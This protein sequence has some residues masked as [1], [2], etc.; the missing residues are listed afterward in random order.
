MN[1]IKSIVSLGL[2]FVLIF[3]GSKISAATGSDDVFAQ[4]AVSMGAAAS[5]QSKNNFGESNAALANE[6]GDVD[7]A[8]ANSKLDLEEINPS[9]SSRAVKALGDIP[10]SSAIET[11]FEQQGVAL[12][13]T[14][15]WGAEK[16]L[17]ETLTNILKRLYSDKDSLKFRFILTSDPIPYIKSTPMDLN[18]K[19][20]DRQEARWLKETRTYGNRD[21]AFPTNIV[22][23][24]LLTVPVKDGIEIELSAGLIASTKTIDELAGQLAIQLAK[25]NNRVYGLEEDLRFTGNQETVEL[26]DQL[27]KGG[28][29]EEAKKL[30]K[31]RDQIVAEF[32]AIERMAA[33]GFYPWAIYD[34][35]V[36]EY[37]WMADVFLNSR[38]HYVGRKLTS[39]ETN[40]KYNLED[41]S[42]PIRLL[43]QS[44]YMGYL[45]GID[46]GKGMNLDST[47]YSDSLKNIRL[48]MVAFTQPFYFGTAVH[49]API[50]LGAG[51]A[52]THFFFPEVA[53]W[54][55]SA[56]NMTT[57]SVSNSVSS[58]VE[59]SGWGA[60]I[61]DLATHVK[62]VGK[63]ILDNCYLGSEQL[64]KL[65][66][67]GVS[68][69]VKAATKSVSE[70][71]SNYRLGLA[72]GTAA[73][74]TAVAVKYSDAIAEILHSLARSSELAKADFAA[75]KRKAM[76]EEAQRNG[77]ATESESKESWNFDYGKLGLYGKFSNV[78][79]GASNSFRNGYRV[80]LMR[81][82]ALGENSRSAARAFA[83][84][85]RAFTAKAIK[86]SGYTV[87]AAGS[88]TLKTWETFDR[89][90]MAA[91]QA[92][93]NSA[94]WGLQLG[95]KGVKGTVKGGH[96]LIFSYAPK[97]IMDTKNGL[98][99]AFESTAE[100]LKQTKKSIQDKW[101]ARQNFI[102]ER[103]TNR[104]RMELFLSDDSLKPSE[105]LILINDISLAKSVKPQHELGR[106]WGFMNPKEI[107]K[108]DAQD[109]IFRALNRWTIQAKHLQ[110]DDRDFVDLAQLIDSKS[111]EIIDFSKLT[112][113]QIEI[114]VEFINTLKNKGGEQA[115]KLLN[116]TIKGR[117][118][119]SLFV[120]NLYSYY[121]IEQGKD[122]PKGQHIFDSVVTSRTALKKRIISQLYK[123][124]TAEIAKYLGD[125][126]TE[127][128]TVRE[129]FLA[130][131]NEMW[132]K[133]SF[134]NNPFKK[135]IDD[136]NFIHPLAAVK[137]YSQLTPVAT[138]DPS[139]SEVSLDNISGVLLEKPYQE[140]MS[141]VFE[142]WMSRATSISQLEEMVTSETKHFKVNPKIFEK[143]FHKKLASR[144]DL[145][146]SIKD[147]ETFYK[148]DYFWSTEGDDEKVSVLERP[149]KALLEAKR[150]AHAGS[151]IWN[152]DPIQS[153]RIH[154]ESV[155]KLIAINEYPQDFDA[156]VEI[157]KMLTS[158]GVSTVTDDI[159]AG[160]MAKGTSD[161]INKLEL[162]AVEEGRVFDQTLRDEFAIRQIRRT[163][164]YNNLM[165]VSH[166]VFRDR[167]QQIQELLIVVQSLMGD[168]GIRYAEFLEEVS[169]DIDSK[170]YEAEIFHKA[171]LSR[172]V[173]GASQVAEGT[174]SDSRVSMLHDILPYVKTW[175]AK[176]QYEFLLYLRGNIDATKFIKEQF[177]KFGPERVRKMF[178]GLPIEASMGFAVLYLQGT[179]LSGKKKIDEGYGKKL[180]EYF[181]TKG[182]ND[183]VKD[184]ASLMLRGLLY[185]LEY[186]KNQQFQVRVLSALVAMKP[187]ENK[188]TSNV[189]FD[190]KED[191]SVGETLK[192]ILEQFPGVGPKI[193]QFLVGTNKLPEHINKVLIHTQDNS[194][195]PSRHGMFGDIA[196]IV[197]KGDDIGISLGALLGAGSL[198][199]STLG[200]YNGKPVALQIFR[201][202]VQNNSDLQVKVL[203]GMIDYL[204][205]KGGKEWAFLR[206][207][208]DGAVNAVNREKEYT[209][210]SEKT[211]I[212]RES[213]YSNFSDDLFTVKV[214][215]QFP[216]NKRLLVSD[217]AKGISFKD[218]KFPEEDKQAVGI[219][220]LQMEANILYGKSSGI[221]TYDTDRHAGNYL[222]DINKVD[223][224]KHYNIAP[225]DFGQLTTIT[226]KQRDRVE[227]LFSYSVV[228]GQFG[229]N[230]WIV[231]AIA[232][233]LGLEG[234]NLQILKK[235]I[236]DF[237]PLKISADK[238]SSSDNI[239]EGGDAGKRV[240]EY[241]SL[242]AAIN[243]TFRDHDAGAVRADVDLT[244]LDPDLR[245]GKLDF[246]YTDFV[247]GIIQL[248]QYEDVIDVPSHIMTPS[249]I[250]S[251]RV[252]DKVAVHLEKMELSRMQKAGIFIKDAKRWVEAKLEQKEFTPLHY[253]L[254]RAELDKFSLMGNKKQN[255]PSSEVVG[256]HQSHQA[257]ANRCLQF[258]R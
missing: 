133:K 124:N 114:G 69:S 5:E 121:Q 253:R 45:Q 39:A 171:K 12:G 61:S 83:K 189:A 93:W 115:R 135:L 107:N 142:S 180:I 90:A 78:I 59:S 56:V 117:S 130:I 132:A 157:W 252:K 18:K 32:S 232:K 196:R 139:S 80:T 169:A 168:L 49:L 193:G 229:A 203:N 76:E 176:N 250:L 37:T 214:P 48:R 240:T 64:S 29:T 129:F 108:M 120:A 118:N 255:S 44:N 105:I 164:E 4:L 41:W 211:G 166:K 249:K 217:Y 60:K 71:F 190:A 42:R 34:Y 188:R 237:F 85:G 43:L 231:N 137:V 1:T 134:I 3:T 96:T 126:T 112:K 226:T 140:R 26:I 66:E 2:V 127:P 235:N 62:G 55:L 147:F 219:K 154:K 99:D 161:Q 24:T 89:I 228:L 53:H 207:I 205:K 65:D 245:T 95:V 138:K 86:A 122:G 103:D 210:E 79:T 223:G 128:K 40:E 208:V 204:I 167:T 54:A 215:R 144:Q 7:A 63:T 91:P 248:N 74:T 13:L 257:T 38:N 201:E 101:I 14:I 35:E 6:F 206:V 84:K 213:L 94:E 125:I 47:E 156:V 227:S 162:Y 81:S 136:L 16:I 46:R 197:N 67:S 173:K 149:L 155:Q 222:I 243:E 143:W 194:R 247:R 183:D 160:L 177:P 110:V 198:K 10:V 97:K 70:F 50:V 58:T 145:I 73:L 92:T 254:T 175:S 224:K 186:A 98:V 187:D 141:V 75:G 11:D 28:T 87:A 244:K 17:K 238:K 174:V 19:E 100:G 131:S 88:L 179:L 151:P 30:T 236:Y 52:V 22:R 239:V 181:I 258:Y 27:I 8:I 82:R 241:F 191:T 36:R 152:Y 218:E 184:Y 195:P 72:A 221:I 158:R 178:Q 153:E 33:A 20:R 109:L 15:W 119:S 116:D 202:D 23:P 146:A 225:I 242:L 148:T 212:A 150:K 185:G 31:S 68:D 111:S 170:I 113:S 21:R 182:A 209:K 25:T 251:D 230:D 104:T 159:L 57:Q 123:G 234:K 216:L 163:V 77:T 246:A 256:N 192:I 106:K 165:A 51:A 102:D 200:T 220:L 172:V 199:Y 9:A 233:E